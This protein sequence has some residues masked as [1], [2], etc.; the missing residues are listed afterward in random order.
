MKMTT[1]GEIISNPNEVNYFELRKHLEKVG[2]SRDEFNQ[3]GST[4]ISPYNTLSDYIREHR[5]LGKGEWKP[6]G[7]KELGRF[8]ITQRGFK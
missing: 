8:F 3:Y 5:I 1:L 7:D 6:E 2:I 4:D